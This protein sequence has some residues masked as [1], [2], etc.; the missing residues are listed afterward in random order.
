MKRALLI[1]LLSLAACGGGESATARGHDQAVS[2]CTAAAGGG[3]SS[4]MALV[5]AH[6]AAG[7]DPRWQPMADAM[8][9]VGVLQQ[10]LG[11]DL[12]A[13]EDDTAGA[14]ALATVSQQC[15]A[16]GVTVSAA[17]PQT[18]NPLGNLNP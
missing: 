16:L 13:G 4:A 11:T 10:S 3:A 14:T 9:Q 7:L 1:P 15:A 5:H 18:A 6:Q 12:G 8:G 17:A 2:A